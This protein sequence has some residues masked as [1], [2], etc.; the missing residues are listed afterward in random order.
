MFGRAV[1]EF[2]QGMSFYKGLYHGSII[3]PHIVANKTFH[4]LKT[5]ICS[6]HTGRGTW[7]ESSLGTRY[8]ERFCVIFPSILR[9]ILG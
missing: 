2:R 1:D 8:F 3:T 7:F 6:L 5:V 4:I 9:Q